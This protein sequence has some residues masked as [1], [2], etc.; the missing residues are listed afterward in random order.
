MFEV[1]FF[2]V[3]MFFVDQ[4]VGNGRSV[5]EVRMHAHDY[6]V[7]LQMVTQVSFHSF[8]FFA[9]NPLAARTFNEH[10]RSRKSY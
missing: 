1:V 10:T 5:E 7:N 9:K 8:F 2:Y 3:F 4:A 6:F